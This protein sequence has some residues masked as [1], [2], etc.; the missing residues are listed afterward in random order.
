MQLLHCFC[1]NIIQF[2]D[3]QLSSRSIESVNISDM[4]VCIKWIFVGFVDP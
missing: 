3:L 4:R 1:I 2:K